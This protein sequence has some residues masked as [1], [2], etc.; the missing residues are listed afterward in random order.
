MTQRFRITIDGA[1]GLTEQELEVA[2]V[3]NLG[4]TIRDK[5]K[6]QRHLDEVTGVHVDW[7]ERPP[8]IFPISSWATIVDSDV[9][10]QYDTTSGEIEIVTVVTPEG[11]LVGTGSDHTDRKLEQTDVPWSKQAAPNVLAPTLWRWADVRDHWDEVQ[12]ESYV[13]GRPYQKASVAEFWTPQEMVDSVEGR[14]G[15]VPGTKVFYSGTVVSLDERLD[16]GRQWSLRMIDPV[17]GKTIRHDYTVSVLSE[18]ISK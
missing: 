14:L 15:D 9:P 8:I 5:E 16:F 13:D 4:F 18:E 3:Y 17:T 1:D 2:R 7:P 6:M 11:L 10:V 12:L